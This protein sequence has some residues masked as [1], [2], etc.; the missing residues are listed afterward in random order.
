MLTLINV[1][2]EALGLFVVVRFIVNTI[3][4]A[5][6]GEEEPPCESFRA[7]V[8]GNVFELK[9]EDNV[10]VV[11]APN[12]KVSFNDFDTAKA[13]LQK[14]LTEWQKRTPLH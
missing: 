1:A 9:R 10:F 14:I 2:L 5:I 4:T 12:V 13:Y 11:T 6:F 3:G 7:E 8:D